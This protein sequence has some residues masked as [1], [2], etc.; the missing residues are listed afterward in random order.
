MIYEEKKDNAVRFYDV[1]YD[2]EKLKEVLEKLEKYSYISVAEENMAGAVTRW[3]A[4]KKNIQKRVSSNFCSSCGNSKKTLLPETITLHT[5]NDYDYVSYKY[6]FE[7]L[8][9]FEME[10]IGLFENEPD[11][12]T[13]PDTYHLF[14]KTVKEKKDL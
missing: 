9:D 7:K 11:N 14:F 12:L 1:T 3:P 13:Y 5:G 10:E 8:P 2:K 4:T 6:S